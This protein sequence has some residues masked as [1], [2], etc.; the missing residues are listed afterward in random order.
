MMNVLRNIKSITFTVTVTVLMLLTVETMNACTHNYRTYF[1]CDL[2]GCSTSSGSAGFGTLD[3]LSFVGIRY[4]YQNF[5][6]KDGIFANSPTSKEQFNTYQLW[7]KIPVNE[8][9]FVNAIVPY[10][11]LTRKFNDGVE[12]INGLGDMSVIGWYQLKLYKKKEKDEVDF[13][14][15]RELSAHRLNFGLGIKLP[16]GAF[17]EAL[18]DRINP[19][20]QV[21][22]GSTDGIFSV[23]HS[24][25]KNKF[26]LNTSAT[27]YVKTENKNE[28][29]FG[30]QFSFASNAYY[31]VPFKTS[32]L[33]PF[34][35]ISGDIYNSI[36]QFGE[37]LQ[38]TDGNSVN[39]SI[40]NEFMTGKFNFGANYT[41]P[42]SQHLFGDDVT[43]KSRITLYINYI[44]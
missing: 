39:G 23:M 10:Q 21:G 38:D 36:E 43:A 18:T 30:N 7:G 1:D 8:S 28:Y 33:M 40:G 6:S 14:E 15:V 41:F 4:I 29:R 17:E 20:F 5:E 37:T 35:G 9:F 26:G 44:L 2:C 11:D 13:N 25:S 3:N 31:N 16:T 19:G 34:V 27:Y 12:H 42:V 32:A 22:T 24:Y